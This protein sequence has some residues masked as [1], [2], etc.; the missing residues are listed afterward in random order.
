MNQTQSRRADQHVSRLERRLFQ[1]YWDDG[2]LD[3][4]FGLGVAMLGAC[5]AL[6]LVAVGAAV[7]ALLVP[8]WAPLRRT[9]VEPRMGLVRF[10]VAASGERRRSLLLIFWVGVGALVLFVALF[11]LAAP[12]GQRP[13]ETL[14]AGLPAALLGLLAG[15]AAIALRLPRFLH[16]AGLFVVCGVVVAVV[17]AEPEVAMLAG[18]VPAL[19]TG[20]WLLARLLATAPGDGS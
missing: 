6:D 11:W 20:G 18:A 10:S 9:L 16:Y 12:A 7:P 2:L 14:V 17:G 15:F 4:F 5:W 8:L 1:A 3:L 19:L 13:L